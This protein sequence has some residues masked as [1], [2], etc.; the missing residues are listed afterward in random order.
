[1]EL[2][3]QH[4]RILSDAFHLHVMTVSRDVFWVRSVAAFVLDPQLQLH[5]VCEIG[6]TTLH[7]ACGMP[8]PAD[9]AG[10]GVK[11]LQ[12]DASSP[13]IMITQPCA[14]PANKDPF[15]QQPFIAGASRTSQS[16]ETQ[17]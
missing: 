12:N 13:S 11:F 9:S 5:Q 10:R 1:M 2:L 14:I 3:A 4:L 17:V 8:A 15:D 7:C 16:I 6:T